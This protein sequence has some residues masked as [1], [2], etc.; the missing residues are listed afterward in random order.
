MAA[1][2]TALTIVILLLLGLACIG[3]ALPAD[4]ILNFAVGWAFYLAR[5]IPQIAVSWWG[6]ASTIVCLVLLGAGTHRFLCWFT[7]Q[8]GKPSRREWPFRWTAAALAVVLLMFVSGIA[9]VGITHQ[10]AWLFT[11]PEPIVRGGFGESAQRIRSANNMRQIVLAMQ[12]YADANGNRLP[13]HAIYSE[14]GSPLL[15]WRVQLLPYLEADA[16]FHEF[17]LDEPW[18]SPHNLRLLPRM[19]QVYMP[20]TYTGHALPGQTHYQVFVGRG[21]AFEGMQG[22]CFPVDFPDGTADTILLIEASEPV[23]WTKPQD[24][25]YDPE[26][27]LPKLGGVVGNGF[28]AAMADGSVRYHLQ[29]GLDERIIRAAITRNGGEIIGGDW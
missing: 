27:T 12:S 3:F 4:I 26:R 5:T 7:Q 13:A 1:K 14:Q 16:L 17:K 6:V 10:T 19:P 18:D 28:H 20:P 21:A 24:I 8:A 23:P 2:I 11:S 15:S 29:P 9:A 25:P 22:L